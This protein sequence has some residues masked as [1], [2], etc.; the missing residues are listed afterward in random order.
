VRFGL[1]R[2]I[3]ADNLDKGIICSLM[4][5]EPSVSTRM[6]DGSG[7]QGLTVEDHEAVPWEHFGDLLAGRV[8]YQVQRD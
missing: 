1:K 7:Q 2:D 6:D 3:S 4:V 5:N 8:E